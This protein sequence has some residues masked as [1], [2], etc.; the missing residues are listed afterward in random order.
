MSLINTPSVKNGSICDWKHSTE[1]LYKRR[2]G[3][4]NQLS[5]QLDLKTK[6]NNSFTN[7]GIQKNFVQQYLIHTTQLFQE[8]SM[9]PRKK[10]RKNYS[11]R[12]KS[13]NTKQ[14]YSKEI[15]GKELICARNAKDQY[16]TNINLYKAAKRIPHL[17]MLCRQYKNKELKEILYQLSKRVDGGINTVLQGNVNLN[18]SL[19]QEVFPLGIS[20][21]DKC[22]LHFFVQLNTKE[23]GKR[24]KN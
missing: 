23:I 10:A 20:S 19:N 14:N 22:Q 2:A 21:F 11:Q 24:R 7:S 18:T 17:K 12:E 9:N 16:L 1:K 4:R 6:H 15:V 5:A 3:C 13:K 8:A